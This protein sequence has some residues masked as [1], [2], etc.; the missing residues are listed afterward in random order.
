MILITQRFVIR[1]AEA[2]S[3]EAPGGQ[4]AECCAEVQQACELK[5]LE[6]QLRW[7]GWLLAGH[8][9]GLQKPCR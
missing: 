5:G 3:A 1:C 4:D 9:L 8:M 2:C 6:I 7:A